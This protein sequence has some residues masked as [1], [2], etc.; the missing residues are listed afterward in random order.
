MPFLGWF[1]VLLAICMAFGAIQQNIN[2][3]RK[4]QVELAA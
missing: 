2:W 1:I 3:K 4:Q